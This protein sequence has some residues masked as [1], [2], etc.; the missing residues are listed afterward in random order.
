MEN[1]RQERFVGES[2]AVVA[3]VDQTE[4]GE[5][6]ESKVVSMVSELLEF[7]SCFLIGSA[8][9]FAFHLDG[10][11]FHFGSQAFNL[12]ATLLMELVGDV[13]SNE[14]RNVYRVAGHLEEVVDAWF[15]VVEF[16]GCVFGVLVNEVAFVFLEVALEELLKVVEFLQVDEIMWNGDR[17]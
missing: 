4:M 7:A 14:R 6:K 9:V 11:S 13:D 2:A 3:F 5:R 15:K 16:D 10:E 12:G 1:T 17:A 8:F